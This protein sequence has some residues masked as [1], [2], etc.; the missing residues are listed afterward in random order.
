MCCQY[1]LDISSVLSPQSSVTGTT[2]E[3]KTVVNAA[4]RQTADRV[5]YSI[6]LYVCCIQRAWQASSIL[7]TFRNILGPLL[8]VDER[9]RNGELLVRQLGKNTYYLASEACKCFKGWII[10]NQE[11]QRS[12]WRNTKTLI[13]LTPL[14]YMDLARANELHFSDDY[15]KMTDIGSNSLGHGNQSVVDLHGLR[16]LGFWQGR[17]LCLH[18]LLADLEAAALLLLIA[19]INLNWQRNRT[20]VSLRQ[21]KI[22]ARLFRSKFKQTLQAYG[23]E[24][25]R[26]AVWRAN[27]QKQNEVP[28]CIHTGS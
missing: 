11:P 8:Q 17:E 3:T 6:L 1:S 4:A 22:Q 5:L 2:K 13:Y 7:K 27:A 21:I 25:Q 14:D 20:G 18:L 28:W 24:Q 26:I 19:A 12:D 16:G 9:E 10:H 23:S 15:I